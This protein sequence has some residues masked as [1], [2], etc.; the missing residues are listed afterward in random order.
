MNMNIGYHRKQTDM[1]GGSTTRPR[2]FGVKTGQFCVTNADAWYADPPYLHNTAMFQS[3]LNR[4][5]QGMKNRRTI[6]G[7][8]VGRRAQSVY[9]SQK[10]RV[11]TQLTV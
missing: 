5:R 1:R 11:Y 3:I 9:I 10:W 7:T 8:Y 6:I 2:P 4:G